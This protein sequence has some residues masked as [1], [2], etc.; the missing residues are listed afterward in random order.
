MK[1]NWGYK[2]VIVYVVFVVGILYLGVKSSKLQFDLVH[3]D[4]YGE[5][6]KYQNVIDASNRAKE[7]GG[8]LTTKVEKGFLS[9]QLP[10]AFVT[11]VCNGNAHL[12]FPADENKDIKKQFTTQNGAIEMELLSTTKGNYTLKLDFEQN[13]KRYY[14]EQKIFL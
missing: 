13:G 2:I 4:Y 11:S 8:Q 14:F 10:A 7:L 5:E 12:Y 3:K 6:L 1:L 9:I